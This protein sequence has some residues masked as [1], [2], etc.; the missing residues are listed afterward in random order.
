MKNL[1]LDIDGVLLG[2]GSVPANGLVEFL[3]FATEN[4]DCYW[5]TTHC[6]GD[7]KPVFLYLVGKVPEEALAYIQKIKPT[8]WGPL[9]KTEG[10]DFSKPFYWL[11][12][13]LFEP[14]RRVLE[15]KSCLE[16]FI[17]IELKS[18]PNQLL[19][20]REYLRKGI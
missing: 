4:F 13:D 19:E 8:S 3:K 15:E 2:H 17:L 20:A 1:Y 9:N 12:D 6:N 14:E 16:N 5:L 11:D 7:V 10:I 18:N